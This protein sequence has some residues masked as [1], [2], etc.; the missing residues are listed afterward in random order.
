MTRAPGGSAGSPG[1]L[2]LAGGGVM[3]LPFGAGVGGVVPPGTLRVLVF[4]DV[5][6]TGTVITRP[7]TVTTRCVV[8]DV[9]EVS[10]TYAGGGVA[11]GILWTS[12]P[13]RSS[14]TSENPVGDF[15]SGIVFVF[16]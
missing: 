10:G 7:S 3:P 14:V 5:L 13:S 6:V 12:L 1:L 8:L 2:M 11:P 9:L 15:A 4:C 16:V